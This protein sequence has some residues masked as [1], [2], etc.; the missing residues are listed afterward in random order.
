MGRWDPGEKWRVLGVE[1]LRGSLRIWAL[2]VLINS[3]AKEVMTTRKERGPD[4]QTPG[5]PGT[6][7][8]FHLVE[9]E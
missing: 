6:F 1:M 5:G 9:L 4:R 3:I 8:V 7:S 2:H